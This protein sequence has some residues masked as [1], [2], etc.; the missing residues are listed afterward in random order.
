MDLKACNSEA[1]NRNTGAARRSRQ[2][3]SLADLEGPQKTI[4]PST[5]KTRKL[6]RSFASVKVDVDV[7]DLRRR[8]RLLDRKHLVA[9]A[10][11]F[12]GAIP[13]Q[14]FLDLD[15]D[16]T[17]G[18]VLQRDRTI[19]TFCWEA[20]MRAGQAPRRSLSLLPLLINPTYM[21]MTCV[22]LRSTHNT[23]P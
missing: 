23:P 1:Q 6:M 22:P 7:L 11:S 17:N 13:L 3:A 9:A 16:E 18:V 8:G 2:R 21:Y 20:W 12:F 15:G 4:S 14:L 19:G 10:P 5:R